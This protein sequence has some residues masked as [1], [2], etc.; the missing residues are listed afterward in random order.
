MAEQTKIPI[1]RD[2][3]ITRWGRVV[4]LKELAVADRLVG[5]RRNSKGAT[6]HL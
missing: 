6:P 5:K 2:E 3:A 1:P 4:E